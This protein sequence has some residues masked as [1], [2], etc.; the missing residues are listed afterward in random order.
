MTIHPTNQWFNGGPVAIASAFLGD[1]SWLTLDSCQSGHADMPPHAP[2][3]WWNCRRGWEPVELMYSAGS[4][5]GE[6]ARPGVDNEAHYENRYDN[7]EP[8]LPYWN[9][10]DV[11][12]GS[13]QSV[14]LPN[15]G[16]EQDIPR[17][18]LTYIITITLRS[19]QVR[20]V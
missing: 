19:S 20:P 5:P 12:T 11:R 14:S 15:A 4:R 1:R 16:W 2:I 3:P 17:I 10:S 9:A 8:S 6:H 18:S 13:W 7:G